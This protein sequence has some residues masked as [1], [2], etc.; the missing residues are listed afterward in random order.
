MRVDERQIRVHELNMTSKELNELSLR[1]SSDFFLHCYLDQFDSLIVGIKRLWKEKEEKESEERLKKQAATKSCP[2]DAWLPIPQFEMLEQNAGNLW[3]N[4]LDTHGRTLLHY[5]CGSKQELAPLAARYLLDS[6]ASLLICDADGNFPVHYLARQGNVLMF[7]R[8]SEFLRVVGQR[9]KNNLAQTAYEIA[10]SKGHTSLLS[11]LLAKCPWI[12]ADMQIREGRKKEARKESFQNSPK[13]GSRPTSAQSQKNSRSRQANSTSPQRRPSSARSPD[14]P[15]HSSPTGSKRNSVS[16]I[17]L[18]DEDSGKQGP[19]ELDYEQLD[20]LVEQIT[21]DQDEQ[22]DVDELYRITCEFP[23][24]DPLMSKALVLRWIDTYVRTR[25]SCLDIILKPHCGHSAIHLA[26]INGCDDALIILLKYGASTDVQN[27]RGHTPLHLACMLGFANMVRELL[28]IGA[29]VHRQDQ[30]GCIPI[31]LI[32]NTHEGIQIVVL[33]FRFASTLS[34]DDDERE[35]S[36]LEIMI[37]KQH[38][39]IVN[40]LLLMRP[41]SAFH[42]NRQGE[43]LLHC[44]AQARFDQTAVLTGKVLVA[45]GVDT[46]LKNAKKLIAVEVCSELYSP[47]SVFLSDSL[48]IHIQRMQSIWH[49]VQLTELGYW[50]DQKIFDAS[51]KKF[52]SEGDSGKAMTLKGSSVSIKLLHKIDSDCNNLLHRACSLGAEALAQKLLNSG[53]ADLPHNLN[54]DTPLHIA[55]FGGHNEIILC[56]FAAS[57]SKALMHA[58]NKHGFTA[59]DLA[60]FQGHLPVLAT[61]LSWGYI[62]TFEKSSPKSLLGAIIG[63]RWHVVVYL[64]ENLPHESKL[65]SDKD[66]NNFLHYVAALNQQESI[67]FFDL[68]PMSKCRFLFDKRCLKKQNAIKLDPFDMAGRN[69]NV[70]FLSS[71]RK[72]CACCIVSSSKQFLARRSLMKLHHLANLHSTGVWKVKGYSTIITQGFVLWTGMTVSNTLKYFVHVN[73]ILLCSTRSHSRNFGRSYF[74]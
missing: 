10:R 46:K 57:F 45:L 22:S 68:L 5:C 47:L 60:A 66:D 6:K 24:W 37:D 59:F 32:P 2:E 64:L 18:E 43:T 39:D 55:A 42:I 23:K 7:E 72:Y 61:F 54:G 49:L 16:N 67:Q 44:V 41:W 8:C 71:F 48:A 73:V 56:L 28:K 27:D 12:A 19:F 33:L 3:A 38:F 52:L 62:E 69:Q 70:T 50:N 25:G 63:R 53:L 65:C 26:V 11:F 4:L 20:D 58:T 40:L 29:D 34:I 17:S 35:Q 14:S 9:S 21:T 15:T 51:S 13:Y 36:L 30:D 31:E 1:L 74:H